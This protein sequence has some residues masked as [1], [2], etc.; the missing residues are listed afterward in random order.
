LRAAA[1][2]EYLNAKTS[3]SDAEKP[4]VQSA[5]TRPSDV[6]NNLNITESVSEGAIERGIMG[7][8]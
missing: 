8:K 4:A 3:T 2:I 7:I 6:T 5:V 1:K